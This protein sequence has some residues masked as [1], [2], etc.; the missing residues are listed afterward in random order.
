MV[1][2]CI[3]K[4]GGQVDVALLYIVSYKWVTVMDGI[5]F[6]EVIKYYCI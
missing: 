6:E 3:L 1:E 2:V 5:K 4:K